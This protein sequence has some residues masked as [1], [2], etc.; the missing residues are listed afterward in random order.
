MESGLTVDMTT[1]SIYLNNWG[2]KQ[3]V[4]KTTSSVFH[5]N[6]REASCELNIT[7]NNNWLQ[8]Q[9]SPTCLGIN[10]DHTLTF[11]QHP[12][13]L[14][15]KN[16]SLSSPNPPPSWHYLGCLNQDPVHFHSGTGLFGHPV[17]SPYLVQKCQHAEA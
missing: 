12:K 10:L 17:L 5:F 7:V 9:A 6:N 14:I 15:N 13:N 11:W 16:F 8:F 4:A 1:L 2:L 3:P